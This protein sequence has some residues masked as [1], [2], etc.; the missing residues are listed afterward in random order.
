[1]QMI[2][3][4]DEVESEHDKLRVKGPDDS[5]SNDLKATGSE[6][7]DQNKDTMRNKHIKLLRLARVRGRKDS[8]A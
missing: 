2:N 1:M 3:E 8:V 5:I 6:V 7:F 4:A